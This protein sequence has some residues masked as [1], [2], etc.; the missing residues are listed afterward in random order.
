[1]EISRRG[2]QAMTRTAVNHTASLARQQMYEK[3]TDIIG[4]EQ[5]SATLDGRTTPLCR[6]LD[7][8]KYPVG[9][10]PV[11]GRDTHIGCRSTIIPVVKT[12]RELGI[13]IDEAPESTRA[14]FDGQV[15]ESTTYNEWLK[16]QDPKFQDSILGPGR[17]ELFRQGVP[18]DKFVDL[19]SGRSFTLKELAQMDGVKGP[20]IK[21]NLENVI[22]KTVL[23]NRQASAFSYIDSMSGQA[24]KKQLASNVYNEQQLSE[25]SNITE[26]IKNGD[27][28]ICMNRGFHK[29]EILEQF[30]ED[31][32]FKNQFETQT[33]KGC[34]DF[35]KGGQRDQWEER[36]Y[37]GAFQKQK[38]YT[39]IL[40]SDTLLAE[41]GKERPRYGYLSD[42]NS[43]FINNS[44][45]DLTFVFK[46]QAVA[47]R[48][49]FS[50]GNSSGII[51]KDIDRG[52]VFTADAPAALW[53]EWKLV[54][55]PLEDSVIS[56][57]QVPAGFS[58]SSRYTEVQ[59]LGDVSL[60]DVAEIIAPKH[61]E[62]PEYDYDGR[63]ALL[64][65]LSKKWG[66]PIRY[67][68]K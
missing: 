53:R 37:N 23:N 3:N 9:K 20:L 22:E 64:R 62:D 4:S 56:G 33:S 52:R 31:G 12:W 1:M 30:I 47:D 59:F 28:P 63:G 13:D 54:G 49:T 26:Q 41:V 19:E 11:P 65:K 50:I 18:V 14:S 29:K 44:Y 40:D 42:P 36:L 24:F 7:G 5:F 25:I 46:P 34:L 58:A 68:R 61:F 10:A 55:K 16:G 21:E 66:I 2:A 35:S 39:D 17:G 51:Q 8:K 27:L 60:N 43:P 38:A 67:V 48:C 32:N 15:P 57:K 45:G 6:A